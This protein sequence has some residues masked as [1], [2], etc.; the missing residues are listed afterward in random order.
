LQPQGTGR[1]LGENEIIAEI[2]RGGSAVVYRL[3]DSTLRLEVVLKVLHGALPLGL[4][5]HCAAAQ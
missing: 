1:T 5:S 4:D 3:L 2:G